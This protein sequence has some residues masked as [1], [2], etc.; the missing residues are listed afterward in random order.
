MLYVHLQKWGGASILL[1]HE[2]S[3]EDMAPKIIDTFDYWNPKSSFR[4]AGLQF[5][6]QLTLMF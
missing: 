5:N 2:Y 4:Q 6:K 1:P 3:N